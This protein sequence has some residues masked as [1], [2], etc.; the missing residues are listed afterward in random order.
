MDH[1]TWRLAAILGALIS[2]SALMGPVHFSR[3]FASI[4][5]G[6]DVLHR[7]QKAGCVEQPRHIRL[8]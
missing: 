2:T 8:L 3:P 7:D 4:Y 6:A 5:P 1:F